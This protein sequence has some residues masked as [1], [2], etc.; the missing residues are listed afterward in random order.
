MF[1]KNKCT[2]IK[3]LKF[4]NLNLNV[5]DFNSLSTTELLNPKFSIGKEF[6]GIVD[7]DPLETLFLTR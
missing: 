6:L 7:I 2:E 1:T 5:E 4:Q 3:S